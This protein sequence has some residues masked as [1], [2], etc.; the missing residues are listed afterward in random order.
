MTKSEISDKTSINIARLREELAHIKKRDGELSFRGNKTE[1]YVNEF[2]ILKPKQAEEL[3]KKLESLNIPRLKDTHI[4]KI[5]DLMPAS[6]E[7]LKVVMQGYALPVTNENLKKIV[8]AVSKYLPEKKVH[9]K[10]K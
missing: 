8:D 2:A 4:N 7:E 6:V 5:I 9:E 3:F 1:E 10:K